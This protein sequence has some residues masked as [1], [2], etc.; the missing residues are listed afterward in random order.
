MK[1]FLKIVGL[2]F[3]GL[4]VGLFLIGV[5][6]GGEKPAQATAPQVAEQ[7]QVELPVVKASD[8][9]NAYDENTVAADQRFKGQRFK[10]KGVVT[11]INTNFMGAPVVLLRGGVNQFLEP[12]FEFDKDAANQLASLKKGQSVTLECTGRGDVAKMPTSDDCKLVQ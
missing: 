4:V 2:V 5:F 3:L 10:V 12:H 9:A 11:D 7:K 1:K 6:V 8:L